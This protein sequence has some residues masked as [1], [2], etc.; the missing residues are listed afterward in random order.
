VGGFAAAVD[1]DT[2]NGSFPWGVAV[3]DFNDD[4]RRDLVTANV[5]TSKV[6]VLLGDFAAPATIGVGTGPRGIAV[7]DLNGD[8]KP[9]LGVAQFISPYS[10]A[11]LLGNG[12]GAC[13]SPVNHSALAPRRAARAPL[14]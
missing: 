4:G 7:A 13:S 14:A 2:G 9:D 12:T 5:G 11:V 1:H 8:A 6:S 3:A 10:A